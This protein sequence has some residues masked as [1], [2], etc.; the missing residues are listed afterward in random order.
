MLS[1]CQSDALKRMIA[2]FVYLTVL[3]TLLIG[4]TILLEKSA[5]AD[6]LSMPEMTLVAEAKNQGYIG[7]LA[8]AEVIRTRAKDRNLSFER[9][10]LQPKQFS[11]W[12]NVQKGFAS[13][14]DVLNYTSEKNM[15]TIHDTAKKAWK[16]S[17]T[18]NITK[19]ANLYHAVYVHP[20]WSKSPKVH[21]ITAVGKHLFYRE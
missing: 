4:S 21:Y 10:C 6:E 11:C 8:V 17:A 20:K 2:W 14:Y 5:N 13:V 12:N 3:A 19:R 9:V 7:M 15:Q 16:D 1:Q 18:T